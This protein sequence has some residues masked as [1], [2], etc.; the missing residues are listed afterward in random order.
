MATTDEE[1]ATGQKIADKLETQVRKETVDNLE[2]L[3]TQNIKQRETARLAETEAILLKQYTD[4][5]HKETYWDRASREA[6]NIIGKEVTSVNDWRSS[7]M[8]L[9]NMFSILN[10]AVNITFAHKVYQPLKQVIV[11]QGLMAVIDKL[12]PA[13]KE[14]KEITLPSLEHNIAFDENNKLVI[15]P[16]VRSDNGTVD[17]LNDVFK[18]AVEK[19]LDVRGY[20]KDTA[21]PECF[22][23]KITNKPL[24]KADFDVLRTDP[25]KGI[26]HFLEEVSGLSFTEA[27]S[28]PTPT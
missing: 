20:K 8:L 13:Y 5:D 23:D 18:E 22:L 7:M 26:H 27:P 14:P 11:D 10:K 24:T 21:K 28:I 2:A 3:K 9:L 19:W 17:G 12:N 16:L 4:P 15:T 1:R 6:Q 25:E